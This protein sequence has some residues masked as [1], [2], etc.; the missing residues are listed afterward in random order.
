MIQWGPHLTFL[1]TQARESGV[2]PPALRDRPQVPNDLDDVVTAFKCLHRTRSTGFSSNP[3]PLQE[4]VAYCALFGTPDDLDEFV[5][6]LQEMDSEYL[7]ITSTT[8]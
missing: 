1:H 2:L 8:T 4:I 7:T 6:L 3:I 5:G